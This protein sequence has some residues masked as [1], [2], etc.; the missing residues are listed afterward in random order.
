LQIAAVLHGRFIMRLLDT[1]YQILATGEKE[2][3]IGVLES[4]ILAQANPAPAPHSPRTPGTISYR[5]FAWALVAL[6]MAIRLR[7]YLADRSLWRDE[8]ALALNLIHR[9]FADL[10]N[11]LTTTRARPSVS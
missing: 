7:I 10:S 11:R 2:T 3:K 1:H 8:A 4:D 9:S 5:L 6:G